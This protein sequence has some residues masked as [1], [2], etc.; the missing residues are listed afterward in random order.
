MTILV[1]GPKGILGS[2]LCN[3]KRCVAWHARLENPDYQ[4]LQ[5]VNAA[6]LCAGRK[7]FHECDGND[8]AF[9]ADVDGNISIAKHLMKHGVFVV[10]ISTEAVER[11][12]HR[13]AYSSN[14]LLVEQFLWTQGNNAIIRPRR[15]DSWNVD[16]LAGLCINVANKK[17]D[18][19][20][21]WP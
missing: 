21:H 4:S 3:D 7:G 8:E 14:R 18:G 20:H 17:L 19:V 11:T 1:T 2:A 15:F 10:F 16:G 5:L 9:R 12:G 13:A 6:I